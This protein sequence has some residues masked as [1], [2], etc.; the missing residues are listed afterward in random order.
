MDKPK[1]TVTITAA[2]KPAAP[3]PAPESAA[4]PKVAESKAVIQ[5][6]AKPIT[7]RPATPKTTATGV[8]NKIAITSSLKVAA[9]TTDS[10]CAEIRKKVLG[11]KSAALPEVTSVC[12][13][14]KSDMLK[15]VELLDA[16]GSA[17]YTTACALRELTD[18]MK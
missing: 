7:P 16:M 2:V 11:H 9:R 14:N 12:G 13:L 15:L 4:A 1:K 8:C 17:T 18:K 3:K 6:P 10:I 5:K